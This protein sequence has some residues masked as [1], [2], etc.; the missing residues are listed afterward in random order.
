MASRNKAFYLRRD[1]NATVTLSDPA[2]PRTASLSH[3]GL[4]SLNAAKLGLR[5]V[6]R[7]ILK[8]PRVEALKSLVR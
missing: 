1:H 8:S 3:D 4:S 6:R 2:D 7:L 5:T